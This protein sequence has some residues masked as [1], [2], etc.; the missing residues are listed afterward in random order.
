MRDRWSFFRRFIQPWTRLAARRVIVG[1]L[2]SSDPAGR[3][4]TRS[5]GGKERMRRLMRLVEAHRIDLT[6]LLTHVFSW[7]RSGEAY[8][9]LASRRNGVLKVAIRVH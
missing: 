5:D 4:F 1:R 7:M 8:E 6:P 2:R 9:L 3:R